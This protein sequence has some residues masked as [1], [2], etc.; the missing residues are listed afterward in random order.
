MKNYLRTLL[1]RLFRQPAS[2]YTR[3]LLNARGFEIGEYSYGKPTVLHWGEKSTL[4]IGKFCSI[5]DDVTIFL[6]GNHRVDWVTTYP[7]SVL[8]QNFPNATSLEGHPATKGDVV[9]GS[10][11][12]IGQGVKIL[13]GVKVGH[14]AVLAAGSVVTKDVED[15]EMVGGNPAKHIK[16]RFAPEIIAELL[17]IRWWDWK[18]KRINEMVGRLCDADVVEFIKR[19][20]AQHNG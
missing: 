3:D 9:I 20:Q 19:C 12:W 14:G 6:G 10:D 13:S 11:V 8:H 7:F 2:I 4:R 1:Q 15:Y 5:A 18:E 16:Y 17:K